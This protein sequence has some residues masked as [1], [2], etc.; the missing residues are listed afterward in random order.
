MKYEQNWMGCIYNPDKNIEC[1]SFPASVPGNI[2]YDYY[3]SKTDEDYQY[4]DN[5]KF[6]FDVE[7]CWW[8]YATN[9][10]YTISDKEEVW[11]VAEGIDYIFDIYLDGKK[12]LSKEGMF[13]KTEINITDF[14]KDGSRLE[15]VIHPHPMR[16]EDAYVGRQ[17]ATASCKPAVVYGWD[18]APRLLTS[19]IWKPAYIETRKNDYIK[20]VEVTYNL[21]DDLTSA[22]VTFD[23]DCK[24]TVNYT[25]CDADGKVLYSGT[26]NK[27]TLSNVKLW[28]CNGHGEPYLYS[29]T[30]ETTSCKKSGKIGFRKVK[31]VQNIGTE[32]EP[33]EFPKGRYPAFITIELNGKRI[34]S[35]GANLVNPDVFNGRITREYYEKTVKS[36]K[37][38][39]MN[40]FRMWGGA[41]I[42]KKEFYDLC[43]EYGIMVWQEFPLACGCYSEE[44]PY[45]Y[46]LEREATEIIKE[47]RWHPSLVLWCGGNELFNRW[48]GMSEQSPALRLLNMLCYQLDS[49]K[50]FIM[51]SPLFGMAH[52]SYSFTVPQYDTFGEYNNSHNTAYTEFG[53][54][55]IAAYEVLEKI[56]PKDEIDNLERTLS[57]TTH[58]AF[59]AWGEYKWCQKDTIE[60]YF[61]KNLSVKDFIRYSQWLQSIG[62]KYVFEEARRQW[63]YCS[64]AINWCYNEPWITA[65]NNSVCSYPL[66]PKPCYYAIKDA[67]RPVLPS[68]RIPKFFWQNGETFTA[69]IWYLNDSDNTVNDTITISVT[70][71]D[72]TFELL[73]WNT[74]DVEPN[75]NKF[76]PSVNFAL[77]LV[78]D[79]E[80]LVLTLTSKNGNSSEYV[81]GYGKQEKP[82]TA[83]MLNM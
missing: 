40:I 47:L 76:G 75:K 43:D 32:G 63:P 58:H 39:N 10:H 12:L 83:D 52:G 64:M 60:R 49:E 27:F 41:G 59:G 46:L 34:F 16:Y 57:W 66:K 53:Q 3:R 20:N 74:G 18:F 69:D 23:T 71:G 8:K 5:Y 79:T 2:Q 21:S 45:L 26:D 67:L 42:Q 56:I 81:L 22:E 11:F 24:E 17:Q 62:Y 31:L 9:L 37:E 68:A 35:K 19:G 14:A 55:S 77:P 65:A 7:K 30:A 50:P 6:F 78:Y 80:K 51:T 61:G 48:S 44:K 15:V 1:E 33:Y 82:N 4:S 29:W 36:A 13:S 38:C 72:E 28:W 25:F 73:S 70:I 54:P